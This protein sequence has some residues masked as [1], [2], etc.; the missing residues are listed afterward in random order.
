[1]RQLAFKEN[2]WQHYEE[3]LIKNMAVTTD[4]P[5]SVHFGRNGPVVAV[6]VVTSWSACI[7]PLQQCCTMNRCGIL[8]QLVGRNIKALHIAG[9]GMTFAASG[10]YL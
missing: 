9:V 1:M 8:G 3:F 2:S 4:V 5:H 10:G 7:P 6:T